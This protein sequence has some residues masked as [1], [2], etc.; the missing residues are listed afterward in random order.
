MKKNI[1]IYLSLQLCIL[2][3]S[4]QPTIQWQNT[5]GGN[6]QDIISNVQQTADGGFILSGSSKSNISGD[7]TENALSSN[8]MDYWIVKTD[9]LGNIQWQNTIGG[10]GDDHLNFVQQT[11]DGGFIL[12]GRSD[13]DISPDKTENNIGVIDYWIVKT[14][15]LGNIQWDNTIGGSG[16]D[17]LYSVRQTADGGYILGGYSQSPIS[18]DKTEDVFGGSHFDYW[19]VK[20]DASGNVQ[21]DNTIGG[22]SADMLKS[23]QQTTDG[24]YILGGYSQSNISG[25]KTENSNGSWDYW[26]VKTDST[27]NILWQNT[28]GGSGW[29]ELYSIQQTADGGY[30]LGGYSPS[31]ISGDKTENS[32]GGSDFWIVKTDSLGNIQWQN[33]IGGS[34]G[35]TPSSIQLTSDGGYIIGGFSNSNIS[36]DKTENSIG[37]QDYWVVKTNSSGSIQWQKTIGGNLADYISSV[38]QTIDGGYI[39]GGYSTSNISGDKTENCIGLDDYW[40]IKLAPDVTTGI[41][42]SESTKGTLRIFPNPAVNQIQVQST[43]HKVESVEIFD[44]LGKNQYNYLNQQQNAEQISI[45]VSP[46]EKGLYFIRVNDGENYSTHKILINH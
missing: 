14:D 23:I 43:K 34:S 45:D 16:N 27:G 15:S 35:D 5:I 20:T 8:L 46:L 25:D 29:E 17:H 28:I 38:Q 31:N 36:G 44:A 41:A 3:L 40:I 13:S 22:T 42:Q 32:M 12:G 6:A 21:W 10:T 4:A 37:A 2:Y 39:M 33:T 7:K 18:G 24:G 9:S 30:I 19:I 26:I 11:T 1:L